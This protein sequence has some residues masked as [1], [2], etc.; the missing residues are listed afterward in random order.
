MKSQPLSLLPR[1]E[2]S[3]RTML[4]ALV[5]PALIRQSSPNAAELRQAAG[6]ARE[7]LQISGI[8]PHLAVF[9]DTGSQQDNE[10]GIGA[11]VAWAGQVVAA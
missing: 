9:N 8:Y 10:C 3:R 6:R 2:L 1:F 5:S 7:P 4:L 11:V